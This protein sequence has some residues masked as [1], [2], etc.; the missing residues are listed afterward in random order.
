MTLVMSTTT[1]LGLILAM[2][3]IGCV[4]QI[5]GSTA[6]DAA[7]PTGGNADAAPVGGGPDAAPAAAMYAVTGVTKDYESGDPL[8][9][10][11][12][13]TDGLGGMQTT[14]DTTGAYALQNVPASSAFTFRAIPAAMSSY[15]PTVDPEIDVVNQ[16]IVT[17][18]RVV[19]AVY[20]QRQ[21]TTVGLPMSATGSLLI[22]DLKNLDGTSWTGVP[23]E[24][25]TLVP[26]GM[27]TPITADHY[28]IGATG[29]VDPT[30]LVS[31]E[32]PAP[33]AGGGGG[34]GGGGG[35]MMMA[36]HARVAF[37]NVP[38]GS[39]TVQVSFTPTGATNTISASGTAKT[40]D[41]GATLGRVLHDPATDGGTMYKFTTDIYPIL[42]RASMG[43]QDCANCHTMGGAAG[44]LLILDDGA[45][46]VYTRLMANPLYINLTTPADSELLTK[47]L[48]ETPPNHP[49]A[50]WL[51]T[52]NPYYMKILMWITSGAPM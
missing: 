44:N 14:S 31:T 45:T 30:I 37:L 33:G 15:V 43:G 17:D 40:Y 6:P 34:T 4:G 35:G 25:I 46:S 27:M 32:F 1:K 52:T 7:P 51:D 13:D 9:N 21:Y 47:P 2:P 18:V 41:A 22:V 11:A 38:T 42:Q 39:Y 48:Y 3:L 36:G 29:D 8:A 49:N 12:L 28:F 24:G 19:S 10:I 23:L 20:A 16:N 26:T 50:I 5:N